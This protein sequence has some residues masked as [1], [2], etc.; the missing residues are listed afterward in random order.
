MADSFTPLWVQVEPEIVK[1]WLK[2]PV[3]FREKGRFWLES[4]GDCRYGFIE[5][6]DNPVVI[7]QNGTVW[8]ARW[9]NLMVSLDEQLAQVTA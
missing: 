8:K 9:E 2:N 1:D 5:R 6:Y 3:N 4:L 7:A